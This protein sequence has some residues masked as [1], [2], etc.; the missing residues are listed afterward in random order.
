MSAGSNRPAVVSAVVNLPLHSGHNRGRVRAGLNVTR[1][2]QS[3]FN[4]STRTHNDTR[5]Q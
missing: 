5:H 3:N 2:V 4:T 1:Q